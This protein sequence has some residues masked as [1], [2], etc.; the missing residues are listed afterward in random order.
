MLFE[1]ADNRKKRL[2]E[3]ESR[4]RAK[5]EAEIAAR[6]AREVAWKQF[7]FKM[8][9]F[10]CCAS[11]LAIAGSWYTLAN[12]RRYVSPATYQTLPQPLVS[13]QTV[14]GPPVS[15]QPPAFVPPT[16]NEKTTHERQPA[17][18]RGF[19]ESEAEKA[20]ERANGVEV[21]H[22]KDGTTYERKAPKKK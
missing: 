11:L 13:P 12:L 14:Y 7:W 5:I 20:Y 22:R 21:V 15:Q 17:K 19:V 8:K 16:V 9:V 4:K 18:P 2:Q 1:S 3:A 10:V 6:L